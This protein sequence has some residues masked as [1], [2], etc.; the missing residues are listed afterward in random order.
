MLPG[1]D[2]TT[3]SWLREK[4]SGEVFNLVVAGEFKRGKSTIIN[5]LLGEALL[6]AGVVPLTSVVTVIRSGKVPA[7]RVE[8][9]GGECLTIDLSSLG[10]YVTERG[11]PGNSKGIERVVIDHPS[12]WLANGV[13][14]IDTPG[15]G[16]VYEHNTD[17]T[18]KYMPQADA[19]LFV[20]SVDQPVS[21]AEL[22]FLRDVRS[23]AGKCFCLLNKTDYLR[24]EELEESL[25]FSSAAVREGLDVSVPVLPVSARLALDGRQRGNADL[26][27]H[28]GFLEL[29]ETLRLFM[30]RE[31]T[32][33]WLHSIGR[34]L[35]RLLSQ[36]RFALDLESKLLTEPLE[37]IEANLTAYRF[38]KEKTRRAREDY[39]VLLEAEAKTLQ[40][41]HV[42]PTLEA[43]RQEQQVAI[44]RRIGEWFAEL[45]ELPSR[46]LQARLQERMIAYIRAAYDDWLGRENVELC[47]AFE[48]L[49]ARFWRSL[50]E[51]V[52]ELMRRSS[53]LF[54]IDFVS[55]RTDARWR[56]ESGFYYKFWYE[57]TSLTLLSSAAVLA[58]PKVLAGGLIAKRTKALGVELIEVQAGRIRHDLEERVKKSVQDAQ[59]QMLSQIEATVAAIEAAI[60]RGISIR[61]RSGAR[62]EVRGAELTEL[63]ERI[64]SI[65][66]RL[67]R[68]SADAPAG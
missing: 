1:V 4:L 29:E 40:K 11:N 24:P 12:P 16:S 20:A 65:E 53:E 10:E 5:A 39:R 49:T 22:D 51:S 30:Q 43:F 45:K 35:V 2:A 61:R 31:K 68:A 6:P 57:P 37:Q 32:N 36:A 55:T 27:A 33:A 59:R 18:R 66:A 64:T 62:A 52:D 23:Y 42:E 63:R 50:E 48:A 21:R 25:A 41:E 44:T 9:R 47:R 13:R 3:C 17:E 19:V 60:D 67:E 46:T 54:A 56:T 26:L 15:I 38:E 7:V 34:S 8:L 14:L 28:S 58:L